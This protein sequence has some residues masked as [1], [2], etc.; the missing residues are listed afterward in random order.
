MNLNM[1][2]TCLK[3]QH[4]FKSLLEHLSLNNYLCL[5]GYPYPLPHVKTVLLNGTIM[6][7]SFQMWHF[8]SNRFLAFQGRPIEAKNVLFCSGILTTLR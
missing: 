4:P 7:S 8:Q 1:K 3:L 5:K 6:K 2:L